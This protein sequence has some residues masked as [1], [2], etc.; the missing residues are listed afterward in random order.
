M[1]T[2]PFEI[3]INNSFNKLMSHRVH[4]IL[5]VASPYDAFILE[6][7]GGLTEQIMTEYIGMNFSFGLTIRKHLR[8]G[9]RNVYTH[10]S[11]DNFTRSSGMSG[12]L[13]HDY[14][15]LYPGK[16]FNA[17]LG[18]VSFNGEQWDDIDGDGIYDLNESYTDSNQNGQWDAGDSI[19][20]LD[21]NG[22]LISQRY[23]EKAINLTTLSIE[24]KFYFQ[25][26]VY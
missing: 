23:N 19:S 11:K 8:F 21:E 10:T 6:E 2:D 26:M 13:T 20:V 5:L 16:D 15:N 17:Y 4:E 7:D 14:A 9:L 25:N 22:L 18:C 3:K 24:N 12:E 1:K